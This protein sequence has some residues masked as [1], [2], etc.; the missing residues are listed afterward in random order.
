MRA[1]EAKSRDVSNLQRELEKKVI[2]HVLQE[3]E[4]LAPE[5]KRQFY[6]VIRSE[7]EGGGLGVHGEQGSMKSR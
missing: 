4:L 3:K 7:F 1:I 5:Q 2:D 6:K